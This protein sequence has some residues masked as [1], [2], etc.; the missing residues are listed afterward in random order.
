M[1]VGFMAVV[2]FFLA[3]GVT[4]LLVEQRQLRHALMVAR[5]VI[6]VLQERL[7]RCN[8]DTPWFME[9]ETESDANDDNEGLH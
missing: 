2:V 9:K 4:H 1:L 8:G 5:S 3:V 7:G 6:V